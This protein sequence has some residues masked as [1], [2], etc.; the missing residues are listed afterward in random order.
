MSSKPQSAL[1]TSSIF[2]DHVGPED[3]RDPLVSDYLAGQ[4]IRAFVE[5]NGRP[6]AAPPKAEECAQPE[7]KTLD[8]ELKRGHALLDAAFKRDPTQVPAFLDWA[9]GMALSSYGVDPRQVK[10]PMP[11]NSAFVRAG[12]F[13]MLRARNIKEHEVLRVDMA[14]L[15]KHLG[16]GVRIQSLLGPLERVVEVLAANES[17]ALNRV[18]GLVSDGLDRGQSV[19]AKN[20]ELLR[21][22]QPALA[23]RGKPVKDGQETKGTNARAEAR[24]M[25]AATS[26]TTEPR[27]EPQTTRVVA[28]VP[29]PPPVV[30][31]KMT[32]TPKK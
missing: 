9:L 26:A 30:Q 17:V 25:A 19:I 18:A 8:E 10:E 15:G 21:T 31:P 13:S 23:I 2:T 27:A 5:V 20:A 22:L 32:P 16:E 24:V 7:V 14:A 28:E 6:E 4:I 11:Y 29:A 1:F 12:G 3:L